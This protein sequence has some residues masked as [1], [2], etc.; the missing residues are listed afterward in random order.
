MPGIDDRVVVLLHP[1]WSTPGGA[2]ERL[3]RGFALE[4]VDSDSPL[5]V[6]ATESAEPVTEKGEFAQFRRAELD[7]LIG[8]EPGDGEDPEIRAGVERAAGDFCRQVF[9]R[10]FYVAR[11]QAE[12]LS[13][14]SPQDSDSIWV[15]T[16]DPRFRIAARGRR[17]L[18]SHLA[19]RMF[20]VQRRQD[21]RRVE[22]S[23]SEMVFEDRALGRRVL[24]PARVESA[25]EVWE[26]VEESLRPATEEI[27]QSFGASGWKKLPSSDQKIGA[28]VGQ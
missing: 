24:L 11:D 27:V 18:E 7:L 14:T 23:L 22:V 6:S 12:L 3:L 8:T 19:V 25:R 17:E 20:R 10:T 9:G 15:L 2:E 5:D 4:P 21:G 1:A 28:E 16:F 26:L 13:K